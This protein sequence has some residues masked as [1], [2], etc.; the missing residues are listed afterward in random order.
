MKAATKAFKK[1]FPDVKDVNVARV[2]QDSEQ[3]GVQFYA[4]ANELQVGDF[5]RADVIEG[6]YGY[7]QVD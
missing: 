5:G 3:H 2:V 7:S 6:L 1:V 4:R